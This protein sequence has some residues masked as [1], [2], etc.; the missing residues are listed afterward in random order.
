VAPGSKAHQAVLEIA[1]SLRPFPVVE[2]GKPRKGLFA[3]FF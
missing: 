3:A 2:E 1:R